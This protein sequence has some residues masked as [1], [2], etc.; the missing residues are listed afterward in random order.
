MQFSS[1][2]YSTVATLLATFVWEHIARKQ[3]LNVK[4]SVG[5]NLIYKKSKSMFTNLGKLFAKI[6]SFYTIIDLKDLGKTLEDVG[7]PIL[8]TIVSPYHFV[9][10]YVDQANEYSYPFLVTVGTLTL[11]PLSYYLLGKYDKTL[12]QNTI[13]TLTNSLKAMFS[14]N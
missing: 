10:G 13:S 11:L 12:L 5:L 1:I 7:K 8:K 3:N 4:P 2:L 9:R 6:S 14:K